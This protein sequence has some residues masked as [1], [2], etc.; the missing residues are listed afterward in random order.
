MDASA[1]A[2][3]PSHTRGPRLFA[4]QSDG[5][6]VE[7]HREGDLLPELRRMRRE[8]NTVFHESTLPFDPEALA[9]TVLTK[10]KRVKS[11]YAE[12][13]SFAP[14][15]DTFVIERKVRRVVFMV[16]VSITHIIRLPLLRL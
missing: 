4:L 16:V 12:D 6:G 7:L 8:E 3:F 10:K 14:D 2:S 11:M 13:R 5:M 15:M 1:N 9:V